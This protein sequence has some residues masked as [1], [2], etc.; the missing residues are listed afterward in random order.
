[1]VAEITVEQLKSKI[2]EGETFHLVEVSNEDDF[3]KGHIPGAT[4][5]P[6]NRLREAAGQKFR[7]YEQI[8]VYCQE[9]S[10]SA[11]MTAARI[12]QRLGFS[13]VLVVQ[14][15]KEAWQKAGYGLKGEEKQDTVD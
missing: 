2:D 14:G 15:G 5:I 9:S 13:N 10:S 7:Q 6:M 8:V 11:G 12:L 1:M 4:N 3:N